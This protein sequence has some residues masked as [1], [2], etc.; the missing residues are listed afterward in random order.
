MSKIKNTLDRPKFVVKTEVSSTVTSF[1]QSFGFR[2][3]AR[4]NMRFSA[5]RYAILDPYMRHFMQMGM[6]LTLTLT[7]T[8]T[9]NP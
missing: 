6:A 2:T 1:V 7:L 5:T 4:R 9:P 8:L 3:S